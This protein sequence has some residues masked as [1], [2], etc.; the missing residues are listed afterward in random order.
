MS[1]VMR[2]NVFSVYISLL[3]LICVAH[4]LLVVTSSSVDA[5]LRFHPLRHNDGVTCFSVCVWAFVCM[6]VL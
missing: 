4:C 1:I 5:A 2:Y 6:T 3:T